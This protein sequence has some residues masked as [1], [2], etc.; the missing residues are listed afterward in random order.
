MS[1]YMDFNNRMNKFDMFVVACLVLHF[2]VKLELAT[3]VS[4]EESIEQMPRYCRTSPKKI[5][6]MLSDG[7]V[8]F[9]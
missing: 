8:P 7:Y 6:S 3:W 1:K 5:V 9:F 2:F 4:N